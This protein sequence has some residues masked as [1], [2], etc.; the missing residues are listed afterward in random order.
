[1]EAGLQRFQG[2]AGSRHDAD[3]VGDHVAAGVGIPDCILIGAGGLQGDLIPRRGLLRPDRRPDPHLT[4]HNGRA[5]IFQ[6]GP[7]CGA[8]RIEE[9][10]V[11]VH[12][13]AGRAGNFNRS[14]RDLV[15][16]VGAIGKAEV[17]DVRDDIRSVGRARAVIDDSDL[18]GR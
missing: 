14:R 17:L 8:V 7:R 6:L 13:Q 3:A 2:G 15:E 1:M 18:I 10:I 11:A 5:A 9:E 16:G 4:R 12:N